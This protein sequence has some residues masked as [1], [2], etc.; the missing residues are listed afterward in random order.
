MMLFKT[1]IRTILWLVAF[2][3]ST[4]Y[5]VIS[6]L[7]LCAFTSFTA[8]QF[9]GLSSLYLLLLLIHCLF[10]PFKNSFYS[11]VDMSM[12]I[13]LMLISVISLYRLYAVDLGLSETI[14]CFIC[15]TILI[16]LPLV[17]IVLLVMWR[18]YLLPYKKKNQKRD[19][20][21]YPLK[22]LYQFTEYSDNANIGYTQIQDLST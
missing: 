3:L 15:Q 21:P 1:S 13:N 10:Q 19:N 16:Y 11:A 22:K 9:F 6:V 7:A 12:F 18:R 14:K 5:I 8:H 4:F 20:L 2:Q 17:Y